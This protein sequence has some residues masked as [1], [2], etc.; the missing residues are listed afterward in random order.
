MLLCRLQPRDTGSDEPLPFVGDVCGV[1]QGCILQVSPHHAVAVVAG[2]L[3]DRLGGDVIDE[4]E[5]QGGRQVH[6]AL[7]DGVVGAQCDQQQVASQELCL[8]GDSG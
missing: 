5:D 6:V 4:E 3:E 2:H 7:H 1:E 8:Q